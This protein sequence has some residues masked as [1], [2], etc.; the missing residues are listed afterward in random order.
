MC[1]PLAELLDVGRVI[2]RG[3]KASGWGAGPRNGWDARLAGVFCCGGQEPYGYAF[4]TIFQVID[5]GN[6]GQVVVVLRAVGCVVGQGYE[7]A[8]SFVVRIQLSN[9]VGSILGDVF[10]CANFFELG[11]F[12]I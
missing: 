5:P 2:E 4:L 7:E 6:L 12:G 8:H 3:A 9:K 10:G 11:I 1:D